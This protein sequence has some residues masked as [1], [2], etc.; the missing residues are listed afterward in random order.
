VGGCGV[1][2]KILITGACRKFY[3]YL[4]LAFFIWFFFEKKLQKGYLKTMY[5][6]LS[7]IS[8]FGFCTTVGSTLI[9]QA[10]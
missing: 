10:V 4:L 2:E 9:M 8:V 6:L 3:L 7:S 5:G 1:L